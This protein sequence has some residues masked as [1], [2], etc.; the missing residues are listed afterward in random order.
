MSKQE[1]LAIIEEYRQYE[2]AKWKALPKQ[3][4]PQPIGY[5]FSFD[6][7]CHWLADNIEIS[8][9]NPDAHP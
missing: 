1:F 3:G 5:N 4:A 7:F 6:D 9:D 2:I 8:N